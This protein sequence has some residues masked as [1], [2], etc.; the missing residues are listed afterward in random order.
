MNKPIVTKHAQKLVERDNRTVMSAGE[1]LEL[2]NSPFAVK[3][4]GQLRWSTASKTS[5]HLPS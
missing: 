1:V 2:A 4:D 3:E 5:A